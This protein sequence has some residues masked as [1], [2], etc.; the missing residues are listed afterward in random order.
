ME[1]QC[2]NCE[3]A[4]DD[5]DGEECFICGEFYCNYCIDDHGCDDD[6]EEE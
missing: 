5:G 6:A 4:V 3:E 1:E 2:F